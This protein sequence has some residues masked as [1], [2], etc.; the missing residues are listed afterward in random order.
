MK[1]GKKPWD[2][3]YQFSTKTLLSMDIEV[4]EDALL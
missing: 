2:T 3:H 4:V 1:E